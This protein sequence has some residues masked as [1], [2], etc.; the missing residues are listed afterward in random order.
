MSPPL[1]SSLHTRRCGRSVSPDPYKNAAAGRSWVL[2]VVFFSLFFVPEFTAA[3]E[4][5][6][7]TEAAQ[8]E[9]WMR[10][11]A[12]AFQR[13][14]FDDAA[15]GWTQAARLYEELGEAQKQ[16][17]VL[18][19]LADAYRLLGHHR[20]ALASLRQALISAEK[21][22][23]DVQV[24]AIWNG[25]GSVYLSLERVQEGEDYLHRALEKARARGETSLMAAISNNLGNLWAARHAY[26]KA[27]DAYETAI[28]W[29]TKIDDRPLVVRAETN[30]AKT[31]LLSGKYVEARRFLDNARDKTYRLPHSYDRVY[32]LM[33]IALGYGE[34]RSHDPANGDVLLKLA[35]EALTQALESARAT[36]DLRGQSYAQGYRGK[37]YEDEERYQEAL[38]LTRGA[39]FAAQ[40][41]N[42]PESLYLWEWQM[43]RLLKA[44]GEIDNAIAAYRRAVY[45]LQSIR[46][47]LSTEASFR[48][49]IGPVYFEL[50]DLLLQRTDS[51]QEP[52]R[53]ES[54]LSEARDTVELFKAAEL[55]DYFR[56]DCVDEARAQSTRLDVVSAEAVIIYPVVLSDRTELLVSSPSGLKKF[57]APIGAQELT[58]EVREFRRKLE[59]RTTPEY[60][61]HAQKVYDWLIR[62]LEAELASIKVETLVF[63]P[64]G[65]LRTIPMAALHD[66]RQ[67]LI[68]RYAVAITP[69]L[70]LTDPRPVTRE[71]LKVLA[72]G[73][74]EPVQGFPPLPYVGR[75]VEAIKTLYGGDPL[76]NQSFVVPTVEKELREKQ[77]NVVHIA[78]HGKFERNVDD[79]F[80]LTFDDKLTMDRLDQYVGLFR[81]REDP[82]ELLTLS[83]CETAAGDD[84]AALGL[85]GIA[86]KAGARSAVATLW[87]VNDR[88]SSL[89]V[90]EFYR[91]LQNPA[92]SRAA[93]LQRAQWSLLKDRRYRN[94]SYWS[95]FLLINNWL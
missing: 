30:A 68:E 90:E 75:E 14:H 25:L 91:N 7:P 32:G 19:H 71:N 92:L 1:R 41:A 74:T 28:A 47:E 77:F 38:Q 23:D 70:D 60:L 93:A 10:A 40:Q 8:A 66:G 55:R 15:I 51:L 39:V 33:S 29:G 89:L 31:L 35:N 17:E 61:P 44:L 46:N 43:G 11:G 72:A 87:F 49:A 6:R 21:L 42:A 20:R 57:T 65:A 2:V 85:A 34:L 88:A 83:A 22:E 78:T 24:A 37:L 52:G 95:P 53:V 13:G 79:T 59:K 76:M 62:P 63:V 56:D 80:L 73:L 50:V 27:V 16:N 86:V 84:R 54:Y 67:F 45:S 12:A 81:F 82:L 26:A 58:K 64:D 69:G 4:T 18:I 5:T 94:P 9:E 48:Q 36:G 3:S